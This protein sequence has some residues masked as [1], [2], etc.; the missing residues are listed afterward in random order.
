[1]K[2]SQKS[3]LSHS[4]LISTSYFCVIF[5]ML[6]WICSHAF[7]YSLS[8]SALLN[9]GRPHPMKK[10][11]RNFRG[12]WVL[13]M[14]MANLCC[15]G[16]LEAWSWCDQYSSNGLQEDSYLLDA[17]LVSQGRCSNGCDSLKS[18]R[19]CECWLPHVNEF[20]SGCNIGW[21]CYQEEFQGENTASFHQK[22]KIHCL[23]LW[24]WGREV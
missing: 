1:M 5:S 13:F 10:Y 4:T 16:N 2:N 12:F 20:Y 6:V 14:S 24:Y 11:V 9:P 21:K 15:W 23:P 3:V 7:M 18:C 8:F 19:N 22:A 17:S